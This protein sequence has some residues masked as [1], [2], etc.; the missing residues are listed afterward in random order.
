MNT[1]V[2]YWTEFTL[3]NTVKQLQITPAVLTHSGGFLFTYIF[4][5]LNLS[6]PEDYAYYQ[7]RYGTE[8]IPHDS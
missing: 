4:K 1:K 2:V 7:R 8:Y 6:K 3:G 5:I